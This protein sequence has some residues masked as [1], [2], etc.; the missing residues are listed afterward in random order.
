L[1]ERESHDHNALERSLQFLE[2][3]WNVLAGIAIL[4]ISILGT[5]LQP[6]FVP[7]KMEE[8]NPWSGL[9]RFVVAALIA[10]MFIPMRLWR[11]K[12]DAKLWRKNALIALLVGLG[13]VAVYFYFTDSWTC[14][15]FDQAVV[16]G[17]ILTPHS[18][19]YLAEHPDTS[20]SKLLE[21]FSCKAEDIWTEDSIRIYRQILGWTYI[22]TIW[23]LTIFFLASL[24]AIYCILEK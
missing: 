3:Y 13:A 10:L 22:T 20:C 15:C 6:P 16:I 5:F 7:G 17:R 19:K 2:E 4:I 23:L 24:Q 18:Q 1:P 21:D 8:H 11:R 14:N 12:K 9:A